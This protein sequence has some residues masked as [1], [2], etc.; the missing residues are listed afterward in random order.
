MKFSAWCFRGALAVWL[1]AGLNG[2]VPGQSQAEE[3][4]EP[5]FLAG[6]SAVN[7]FD[8]KGAIESFERALEV[9]PHSASAHFE[10]AWLYDQK[11]P[12]PAAAIYHYQ[13]YLHLQP[14]AGNA[15]TVTNRILACKQE[16]AKAILLP[17]TPGMQRELDQLAEEN[18]RLRDELEKWRSYYRSQSPTNPPG[19]TTVTSPPPRPT[20][21]P[22][23]NQVAQAGTSNTE[24]SADGRR[25]TRPASD[26]THVVQAGETP[27]SIARKYNVKLDALL[28]A[29]PGLDPRKLRVGQTLNIPGP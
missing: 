19:T 5:H 2:C 22:V 12:D 13:Q 7:S 6:K 8:Y 15:E 26:R 20:A 14:A 18:K 4:K 23:S 9:N 27:F 25:P 17:N 1:C 29:N 24:T 11:E 16:L 28:S 10:L 3:E 21:P